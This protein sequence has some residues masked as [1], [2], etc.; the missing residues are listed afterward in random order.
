MQI[1]I[2]IPDSLHLSEAELRSELAIALFQQDRVSLGS[3]SK[4]AGMHIMDF[5]KLIGDRGICI[6]YD[7]EE[8]QQDVQHLQERG[9][10]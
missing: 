6:H 2:D 5:Q 9:W 1:T 7:V 10:L 8:F 3:A 4:I